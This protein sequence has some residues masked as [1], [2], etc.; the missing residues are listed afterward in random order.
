[1]NIHCQSPVGLKENNKRRYHS[2]ICAG[3]AQ[4]QG[5]MP[6][7]VWQGSTETQLGLKEPEPV[8]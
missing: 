4:A 6:K 2:R 8:Q 1:M 3:F 7:K 5:S